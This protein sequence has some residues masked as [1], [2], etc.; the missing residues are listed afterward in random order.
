[1]LTLFPSLV[2]LEKGRH[3]QIWRCTYLCATFSG[4]MMEIILNETSNMSRWKAQNY[5]V[6][7]WA[8]VFN[9]TSWIKSSGLLISKKTKNPESLLHLALYLLSASFTGRPVCTSCLIVHCPPSSYPSPSLHLTY[10]IQHQVETLKSLHCVFLVI[11]NVGNMFLST[12]VC[13]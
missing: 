13:L 7:G 8:A 11:P 6:T 2:M 1:M 4:S 3:D 9:W 10:M 12:S 5:T